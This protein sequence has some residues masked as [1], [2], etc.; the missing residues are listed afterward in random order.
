MYWFTVNWNFG[1]RALASGE[2]HPCKEFRGIL[3]RRFIAL[4]PKPG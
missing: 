3:P 4:A 2:V 1:L